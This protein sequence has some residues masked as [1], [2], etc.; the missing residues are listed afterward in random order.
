MRW[1]LRLLEA[2]RKLSAPGALRGREIDAQ[3]P[4]CVHTDLMRAGLLEDP[5]LG[6]NELK[7][8]WIGEC[9]WHYSAHFEIDESFV[10]EAARTLELVFDGI[11]TSTCKPNPNATFALAD[12]KVLTP[13]DEVITY[14]A[15]NLEPYRGFPTFM[16]ALPPSALIDGRDVNLPSLSGDG[17]FRLDDERWTFPEPDDAE[18][19]VTRLVKAGLVGCDRAVQAALE[20]ETREL[21]PRTAQRRMLRA[22]GMTYTLAR[23]IERARRATTLLK[24]DVAIVEVAHEAGYFDQA[25]LTRSMRRLIGQTP[26]MVARAREQLSFLYNTSLSD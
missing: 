26:A 21:S 7:A 18:A 4:G 2:P 11:D 20:G 22:A 3:V 25:H 13:R 24:G 17:A 19:F 10:A 5:Y 23:Q 6:T 1:S 9:S 15:R 14:V 16:R 8:R 12:G